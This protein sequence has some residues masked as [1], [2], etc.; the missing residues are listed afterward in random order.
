MLL[1]GRWIGLVDID[2]FFFSY[3]HPNMTLPET[4]SRLQTPE[5]AGIIIQP[6]MFG[7]GG[8]EKKLKYGESV[9]VNLLNPI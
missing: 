8:R 3:P 7:T 5:W 9:L 6:F 1:D 4:L 2:E